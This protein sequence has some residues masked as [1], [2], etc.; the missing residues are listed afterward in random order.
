MPERDFMIY[1]DNSNTTFLMECEDG[2]YFVAQDD[3]ANGGKW[4]P[5]KAAEW[6]SELGDKELFDSLIR[7]QC[8]LDRLPLRLQIV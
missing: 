2:L 3:A 8:P 5:F 6:G 1:I 4:T 7:C